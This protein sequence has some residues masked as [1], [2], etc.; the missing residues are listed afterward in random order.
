MAALSVTTPWRMR[1]KQ[2]TDDRIASS[3]VHCLVSEGSS[4]AA[5]SACGLIHNRLT[6]GG[7]PCG[8]QSH[9]AESLSTPCGIER[10][11]RGTYLG[12]LRQFR[13]RSRTHG[14]PAVQS[15]SC[16]SGFRNDWDLGLGSPASSPSTRAFSPSRSAGADS[17][18]ACLPLGNARAGAVLC[19]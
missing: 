14:T 7:A 6:Y 19:Q 4:G 16:D 2:R 15:R 3:G 5:S 13:S 10:A 18:V 9:H 12:N 8:V 1:F 17:R 11:R